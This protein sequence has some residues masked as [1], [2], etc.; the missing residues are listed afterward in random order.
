MD[1]RQAGIKALFLLALDIGGGG[2]T[3]TALSDEGGEAGVIFG[4]RSADRVVGGERGKAGTEQRVGAGGEDVEARV[5]AGIW[6]AYYF[7]STTSI[8][9]VW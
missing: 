7:S 3:G 4:Q 2:T 5:A 9:L 6:S 1:N 8:G